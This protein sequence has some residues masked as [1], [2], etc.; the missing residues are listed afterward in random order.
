MGGNSCEYCAY[1]VYDEEYE[2][3]ECQ[4]AMDEDDLYRLEMT[5]HKECPYF[6]AGDEYLIA[7]KQ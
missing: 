7:R 2:E 6:R 4:V 3:Y 5:K 1:F